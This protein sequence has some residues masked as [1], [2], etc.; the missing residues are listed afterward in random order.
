MVFID[1]EYCFYSYKNHY[2]C[3]PEPNIWINELEKENNI[4][5]IMVFGDFSKGDIQ[6]ELSK[7]R[8]ITNTII[9]TSNNFNTHKK[10][11]TDF[12]MLDY[13]Y[14][15]A[16]DRNDIDTYIIFTG[17]G[18]FQ[19]VIRYL[20]RK[21]HKNVIV[22]GIKD[23]FSKSLYSVATKVVELPIEKV[24]KLEKSENTI[25]AYD[26][27]YSYENSIY[28]KY[29][30]MVVSNMEYLKTKYSRIPTITTVALNVAKHNNLSTDIIEATIQEM[31][32]RHFLYLKKKRYKNGNLDVLVADW[33][34]LKK[35]NLV[36]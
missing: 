8:A 3:K 30:P 32:S 9:E 15:T 35:N 13:I 26:M 20:T 18:H 17:D 14:Q 22:C 16:D 29:Y 23:S 7:I 12:I 31:L 34:M 6:N 5:D 33:D 2:N 36:K 4:S 11:V 24:E 25:S 10:D 19:S 27:N 21:K 28:E 1:Y